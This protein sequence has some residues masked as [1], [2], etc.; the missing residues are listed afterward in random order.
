MAGTILAPHGRLRADG[1]HHCRE[2][3]AGR[4]N[5][6]SGVV[7]GDQPLHSGSGLEQRE[8]RRRTRC[9][10]A[11]GDF[12]GD[13][14]LDMAVANGSTHSIQIMLGNGDGTFTAGTSFAWVPA[15]PP[16]RHRSQ[17]GTLTK[18]TSSTWL[19]GVSPDSIVESSRAMALATSLWSTPFRPWSTRFR[20][21][22]TDF[23]LDGFSDFA[24]AN[25]QDN[26]VTVFLGRGNGS[27]WISSTPLATALSGP[28]AAPG[29]G[30]QQRWLRRS[31]DREQQEQHAHD[32][33][34]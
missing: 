10:I 4:W 6:G 14:K 17:S 19:V 15:R 21:V 7:P 5:V 9:L 8:C 1:Q 32:S 27:F 20:I 34:G 16:F 23:N 3:C 30:L 22:V 24:V 12:N 18:M 29:H 13:G 25:G 2:S 28:G 11:T 33:A 31:H 26:T